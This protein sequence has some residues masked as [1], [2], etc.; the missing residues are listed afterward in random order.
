MEKFYNYPSH[1]QLYIYVVTCDAQRCKLN[2]QKVGVVNLICSCYFIFAAGKLSEGFN[3]FFFP[4]FFAVI[5]ATINGDTHL[6]YII[7]R[8]RKILW[9]FGQFTICRAG[10]N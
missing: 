2:V 10:F 1:D 9:C 4:F 3:S 6:N 8:K 5:F 7:T